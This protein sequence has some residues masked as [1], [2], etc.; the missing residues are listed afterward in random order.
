MTM[1]ATPPHLRIINNYYDTRSGD[2]VFT[3]FPRLPTELRLHVWELSMAK[4]RLI[5]IDLMCMHPGDADPKHKYEAVVSNGVQLHTKLLRVSREARH[6]ALKFYRVHMQCTM[7]RGGL[8]QWA[9]R[10][11]ESVP[12]PLYLNPEHD[13]LYIRTWGPAEHTFFAFIRDLKARDARRVGLGRL[14]LDASTIVA[15]LGTS[16][17]GA[18]FRPFSHVRDVVFIMDSLYARFIHTVGGLRFNH[19]LPVL[20]L[21][22]AFDLATDPRPRHQLEADLK[23][24]PVWED[25]HQMREQMQQLFQAWG[26]PTSQ[27]QGEKEEMQGTP[28]RLRERVLI[29]HN[30]HFAPHAPIVD[31]STAATFL[32]KDYERGRELMDE[33]KLR[34]QPEETELQAEQETER[35][36]RPAVGFWLFDADA[37]MSRQMA[38]PNPAMV[39]LRGHWP[40]LALSRLL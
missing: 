25:L 31:T 26:A 19:S 33:Y 4:Q 40:E 32:Q 27:G 28:S 18:D 38:G 20:A 17:D 23:D 34:V 29:A 30:V 2:A 11:D 9:P 35:D 39:D 21:P 15:L 22:P 8:C 5:H 13:L 14:G 10:L 37:F 1:M 12:Q 6:A 24:T 16:P 3:L 36:A 7:L